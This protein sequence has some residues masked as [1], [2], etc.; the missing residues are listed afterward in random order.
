MYFARPGRLSGSQKTGV[1]NIAICITLVTIWA[2]SRKR[3]QIKPNSRPRACALMSSRMKAGITSI[4]D[5]FSEMPAQMA[6]G[7]YST[8]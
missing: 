5:D 8:I 4:T 3:V 1:K 7:M 2:T 6:T